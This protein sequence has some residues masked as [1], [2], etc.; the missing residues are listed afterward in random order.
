[1]CF[2]SRCGINAR[3]SYLLFSL[4][5]LCE[6]VLHRTMQ[7][8]RACSYVRG[9]VHLANAQVAMGSIMD[10]ANTLASTPLELQVRANS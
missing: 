10:A 3:V 7:M 9:Y 1:M 6:V 8:L 4:E 2:L 5:M